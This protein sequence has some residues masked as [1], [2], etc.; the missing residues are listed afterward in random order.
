MVAIAKSDMPVL[1]LIPKDLEKTVAT[2]AL[3]RAGL[4]IQ[5]CERLDHLAKHIGDQTGA[6]L[7]AEE[8]LAGAQVSR[9]LTSLRRQ[10]PWSD[11]PLLI[12][13]SRSAASDAHRRLLNL[14]GLNAN[15]TFLRRSLSG[16]TLV[17]AVQTALRARRHQFAV[18]DLIEER[19]TVLASI[20]DAFSA[21]DRD[22]RYTHA[23]EKV[24]AFAGMPA[25][26]MIGRVIWEVF[27]DGTRRAIKP[28]EPWTTVMEGRKLNTG[29]S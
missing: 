19:E 20:S 25:S 5:I 28:I 11:L 26:K 1:I 27:P 7:L 14:F 4:G 24:A 6:V 3:N 15:V 8:A 9:F 17:S 2:K 16:P 10:P 22:W 21:L 23:N 18:R 12:L 29:P 13:T